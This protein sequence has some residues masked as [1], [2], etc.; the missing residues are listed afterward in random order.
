[1]SILTY[2]CP[3]NYICTRVLHRSVVCN[4]YNLL[5]CSRQAL[6]PMGFSRQEYWSRLPWPP[7]GDL[8]DSGVE[9]ASSALAGAFFTT[10]PQGKPPNYVYTH[11]KQSNRVLGSSGAAGARR[12]SLAWPLPGLHLLAVPLPHPGHLPGSAWRSPRPGPGVTG[13][14]RR[15]LATGQPLPPPESSCWCFSPFTLTL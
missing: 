2:F 1:M 11:G 13:L 15:V 9:P 7:P 4:S 14:K 12:V 6:P 8:P 5:D 3:R 10:E